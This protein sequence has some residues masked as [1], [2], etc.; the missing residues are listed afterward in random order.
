M[1]LDTHLGH[2]EGEAP[3]GKERGGE[4]SE[5]GSQREGR[6]RGHRGHR[7]EGLRKGRNGAVL[8]AQREG[9]PLGGMEGRGAVASRAPS[10]G[11]M[12]HP[13]TATVKAAL[14]TGSRKIKNSV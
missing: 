3:L 2:R 5:G 4:P 10:G 6:C 1:G 9:A 12:P 13:A 14:F 8:E 7:V 11:T